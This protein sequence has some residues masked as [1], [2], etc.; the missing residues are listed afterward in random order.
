M[1]MRGAYRRSNRP[2]S[3]R[4]SLN[5]D[6]GCNSLPPQKHVSHL[7]NDEFERLTQKIVVDAKKRLKGFALPLGLWMALD[8]KGGIAFTREHVCRKPR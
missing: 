8:W 2:A 4:R 1:K 7:T 3:L 5:E 6:N